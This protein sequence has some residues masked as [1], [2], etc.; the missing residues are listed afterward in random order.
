MSN[1]QPGRYGWYV[2]A[3]LALAHLVS[4]IDR[5]AMGV[6]LVP[7]KIAMNLSDTDLRCFTVSDS[8]SSTA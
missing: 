7:I 2:A 3:V 8:S 1:L 4:M 5:F 6:L